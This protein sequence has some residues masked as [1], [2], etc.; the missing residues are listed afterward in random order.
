MTE[1]F[2]STQALAD[3]LGLRP[4]TLRAKRLRGDGP[5][6]IRVGEGLRSKVLYRVSAVHVWLD[7][8]T[9]TSTADEHTK[10]KSQ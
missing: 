3:M 2:L 7:S 6:Y 10:G 9:Y 4:Q 8:R 5:P 1:E